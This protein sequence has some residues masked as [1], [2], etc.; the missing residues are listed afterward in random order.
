MGSIS[1]NRRI[2]NWTWNLSQRTAN[3]WSYKWMSNKDYKNKF[4]A[5]FDKP[6]Q[7]FYGR[8]QLGCMTFI[9]FSA[10]FYRSEISTSQ[11][12]N[13]ELLSRSLK[14]LANEFRFGYFAARPRPCNSSTSDIFFLFFSFL[15]DRTISIIDS[16]Y[17]FYCCA[18]HPHHRT[19]RNFASAEKTLEQIGEYFSQTSDWSEWMEMEENFSYYLFCKL[20][21]L[22][23]LI[24]HSS[25]RSK[26]RIYQ[27]RV[28]L[29]F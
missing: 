3:I 4:P 10:F 18:F 16:R 6:S 27:W 2:T 24:V 23:L 1:K 12:I 22:F 29:R 9:E 14:W 7:K 26:R 5:P 11:K 25:C 15:Y 8:C 28:W 21:H 17:S 13:C 19:Y 20:F